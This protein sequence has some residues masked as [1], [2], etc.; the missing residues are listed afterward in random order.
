[1]KLKHAGTVSKF[2]LGFILAGTFVLV[3]AA[4]MPFS[5][6]FAQTK[7]EM[8]IDQARRHYTSAR[9]DD[10]IKTLQVISEEKGLTSNQ[11]IIVYQLLGF[12]MV[13]KGYYDQAKEM[14]EK[15]VDLD[16]SIEFNPENVPPKLM[17]IYYEVKKEKKGNMTID[18]R[19]DPGVQTIAILDFDNNSI[20]DD[21]EKWEP[22]G[23]GIAQMLITDLS[24]ATRLKVI[25]RERIQFI[26]DEIE[27]EKNK[28]FDQKTAVRIGKL[29][30]VHSMLFGGIAKIGDLMRLDARLIKVETG[31]LIK[32]EEITDN[33][34]KFIEME[35]KLALKITKDLDVILSKTEVK[36]IK[37]V[38]NK[39]LEAIL[40]YSEGLSFLDKEE[41]KKA[42]AKFQEALKYDPNY[43][44]AKKKIAVLEPLI[45]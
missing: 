11:Q 34:K 38:E 22:M 15:I 8:Q 18:E 26:M 3:H 27:L 33:A 14:V 19:A 31:E 39:S 16:P 6:S 9:F 29:L 44:P 4:I 5:E 30:G 20:G 21:K 35:K 28:V 23:K 17:R 43:L 40:S 24:K 1:M 2:R 36:E 32:A 7:F 13:A 41:Y 45:S 25:E 10:A 12:S 37:K 42:H